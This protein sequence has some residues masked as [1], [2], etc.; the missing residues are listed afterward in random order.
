[1]AAFF[2]N[3]GVGP[4]MSIL[5]GIALLMLPIPFV[6][7]V[8]SRVLLTPNTESACANDY[9]QVPIWGHNSDLE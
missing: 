1:M 5:G 7:Y 4:A 9:A 2:H 8:L 6:L 3:L